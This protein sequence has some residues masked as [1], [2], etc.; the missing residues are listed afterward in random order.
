M[1]LNKLFK[2]NSINNISYNKFIIIEEYLKIAFEF[3]FLLMK[4]I[5]RFCLLK[6]KSLRFYI[7]YREFNEI[8][9]KNNYLLSFLSKNL[10]RFI[11]YELFY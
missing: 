1:Y 4:L 6:K 2:D 5:R 11:N 3:F 7:I 10:K 8:I 9:V